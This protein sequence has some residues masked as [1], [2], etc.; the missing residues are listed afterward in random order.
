[1]KGLEKKKKLVYICHECDKPVGDNGSVF[2][3]SC[4]EWLHFRC[5]GLKEREPISNNYFSN[6]VMLRQRIIN[7]QYS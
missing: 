4:R 6:I 1:M 7:L 2:C 5:E 3:N